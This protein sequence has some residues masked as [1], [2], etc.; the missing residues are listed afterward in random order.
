MG[1][2]SCCCLKGD[3]QKAVKAAEAAAAASNRTARL[4]AE[5][6][7][8]CVQVKDSYDFVVV[9]A[10][11]AGSFV[12]ERLSRGGA[13]SVLILEAGRNN[14]EDPQ[15][16]LNGN[17]ADF[18]APLANYQQGWTKFSD[19]AIGTSDVSAGQYHTDLTGGKGWGGASGINF[20]Q[21]VRPSPEFF[22]RLEALAGVDWSY[23]QAVPLLKELENY[24]GGASTY[25]G[26]SGPIDIYQ[27]ADPPPSPYLTNMA[28]AFVSQ[29]RPADAG[30]AIVADYNSNS[31][32]NVA[33]ANQ[34][35]TRAENGGFTRSY[36]GNQ[37][38]QTLVDAS[39]QGINGRNVQLVSN[40]FVQRVLLNGAK[41][42]TCVEYTLD[43]KTTRKVKANKQIVLSAG[44]IR[45]PGIL[46]LSGI[47]DPAVLGNFGIDVQVNLPDVGNNVQ[48]HPILFS[49]VEVPTAEVGA[50]INNNAYFGPQALVRVV[51]GATNRRLQYVTLPAAGT[52][53][54][55]RL[56]AL[57]LCRDVNIPPPFVGA[58][59]PSIAGAFMLDAQGRGSIHISQKNGEFE[60]LINYTAFDLSDPSGPDATTIAEFYKYLN[61]VVTTAGYQLYY[62]LPDDFADGDA[63]LVTI[64]QNLTTPSAHW[65]GSCKMS[66]GS[67]GVVDAKLKVKGGVSG[68]TI[69]DNS[70]W[71]II[72]DCNTGIPAYYV[73]KIAG[74]FLAAEFSI[75]A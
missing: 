73:G 48:N 23:T 36:A 52:T 45:T 70:I 75:P 67:D 22:G 33:Y 30:L 63:R 56:S 18:P 54:N 42:A 61:D 2:N 66:T 39:G 21:A 15:F 57:N 59:S 32:I 28:N 71:P 55:S 31:N 69:A 6:C 34:T 47:G 27:P 20:L 4:V 9:G 1:K 37:I 17:L 5:C 26:D 35:F 40:A 64:G 43:G 24:S 29:A 50:L 13:N 60:P 7:D 11:S 62:P 3:I 49:L 14:E 58:N 19:I 25:R 12:A 38:L 74:E 16:T 10:G 72:P 44:T 65:A 53:F 46:E 68:L 51:T 8:S 41:K